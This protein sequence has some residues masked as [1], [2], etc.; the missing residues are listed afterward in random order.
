MRLIGGGAG[1]A[2]P[3]TEAACRNSSTSCQQL[4]IPQTFSVESPQ[5]LTLIIATTSSNSSSFLSLLC[6]LFSAGCVDL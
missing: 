1:G 5:T 4:L 2:K 6:N 3:R